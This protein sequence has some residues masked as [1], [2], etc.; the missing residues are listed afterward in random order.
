MVGP[1]VHTHYCVY[2]VYFHRYGQVG[3]LIQHHQR[4]RD[5]SLIWETQFTVVILHVLIT[6]LTPMRA[7]ACSFSLVWHIFPE[8]VMKAATLA[9]ALIHIN[10]DSRAGGILNRV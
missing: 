7:S 6:D 1:T 9:Q 3:Q 5:I 8:V 2:C 10:T 4:N